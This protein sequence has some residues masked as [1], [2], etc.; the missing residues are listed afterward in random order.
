M[1]QPY[2]IIGL[3]M[4]S[5]S[6]KIFSLTWKVSSSKVRPNE[7][8]PRYLAVNPLGHQICEDEWTAKSNPLGSFSGFDRL[9][10]NMA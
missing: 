3:P 9:G 2:S 4:S 7:F 1:G 10:F 5:S 8:K 6:T